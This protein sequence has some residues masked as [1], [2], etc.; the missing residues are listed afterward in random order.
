[1]GLFSNSCSFEVTFPNHLR[2]LMMK[3]LGLFLVLLGLCTFALTGCAE[4]KKAPVKPAAP[5]VDKE[6]AAD[7]KPATEK[8][9][10]PAADAP[11]APAADA[12]AAPAA[13]APAAPA[14]P[15]EP[16]K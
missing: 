15:A 9:A 14:A 5:Q 6:P 4:K 13:D 10:A 3:N 1:M 2:G 11:A 8:P 12:P 16:A 7:E